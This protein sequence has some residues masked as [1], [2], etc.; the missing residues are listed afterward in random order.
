MNKHQSQLLSYLVIHFCYTDH[1]TRQVFP[2]KNHK[3][4]PYSPLVVYCRWRNCIYP[5]HESRIMHPTAVLV[6]CGN[7]PTWSQPLVFSCYDI[8]YGSLALGSCSIFLHHFDERNLPFCWHRCCWFA[9]QNNKQA[10]ILCMVQMKVVSLR[11]FFVYNDIV[12]TFSLLIENLDIIQRRGTK[13][14]RR[15]FKRFESV[16]IVG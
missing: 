9:L 8:W 14:D 4:L 15:D 12:A 2:C 10:C 6:L 1:H 13:R 7:F 16:N 3:A 5:G 11:L